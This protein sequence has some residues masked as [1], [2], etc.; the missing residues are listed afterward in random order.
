MIMPKQQTD[1]SQKRKAWIKENGDFICIGLISAMLTAFFFVA[2]VL[3]KPEGP[4]NFG[5][6]PEMEC[7]NVGTGEPVCVSRR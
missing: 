4:F 1:A 7:K 5:F 6:G 3:P 2:F